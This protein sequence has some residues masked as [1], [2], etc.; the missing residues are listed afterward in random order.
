M[1]PLDRIHRS[2][3]KRDGEQLDVD[4]RLCERLQ[5]GFVQVF[6]FGR[7]LFELGPLKIFHSCHLAPIRVRTTWI[8]KYYAQHVERS[9][10]GL[11]T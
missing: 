11:P 9:G 4:Y 5:R 8:H 3:V 1:H 7:A 6:V 10:R 2:H